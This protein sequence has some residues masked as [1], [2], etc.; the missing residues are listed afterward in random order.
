MPIGRHKPQPQICRQADS[1][2]TSRW[3]RRW[4]IYCIFRIYR[5]YPSC[6]AK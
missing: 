3:Y 2:K 1:A 5:V 4:P 6:I